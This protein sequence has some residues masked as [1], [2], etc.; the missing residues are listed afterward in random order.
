MRILSIYY[1]GKNVVGDYLRYAIYIYIYIYMT[2][3]I[4]FDKL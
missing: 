1:D 3:V 4:P 2:G